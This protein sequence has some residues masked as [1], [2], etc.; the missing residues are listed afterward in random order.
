MYNIYTHIVVKMISVKGKKELSS[1]FWI[2]RS[3]QAAISAVEIEAVIVP[4]ED[5]FQPHWRTPSSR[6]SSSSE[7]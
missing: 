1:L 4:G 2:E 5:V 3:D 7:A 6:R